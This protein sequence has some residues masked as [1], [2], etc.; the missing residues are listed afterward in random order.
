MLLLFGLALGLAL[1]SCAA[2]SHQRHA[3]AICYVGTPEYEE[4]IA[5][6]RLTPAEAASR[7]ADYIRA[8]TPDTF[9]EPKLHVTGRHLLVINGA[10][11]FFSPQKTGGIPLTGY[12]V[13]GMTGRVEFRK[14]DGSIPYPAK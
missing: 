4:K 7:V 10:Y 6:F 14:V 13:D 8:R 2:P 11:H 5:R 12:Y 1:N 3:M 9:A